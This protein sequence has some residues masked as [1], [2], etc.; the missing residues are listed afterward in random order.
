MIWT[1]SLSASCPREGELLSVNCIFCR[2]SM[3]ALLDEPRIGPPLRELRSCQSCGWW[4]YSLHDGPRLE[5]GPDPEFGWSLAGAIAELKAYDLTD[6]SHPIEEVRQYL[7]AR[8]EA[9]FG[10]H[11][12]LFEDTVTSVFRLLGY[13]AEATAYS[14]DG[15]V[16][17]ILRH[18]DGSSAGVQVKRSKNP[19]EVE[20]IR[21]LAG[22]MILGGHAHGVFVTTSR[23]TSGAK[24]ASEGLAT[25]GLPVELLDANAF[26][27]A[28]RVVRRPPYHSYEDWRECHG[29]P[30]LQTVYD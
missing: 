17:V 20:Q 25:R 27:E 9:R 8:Y 22:A 1:H 5:D 10:C 16:D 28:L 2:G 7:T 30:M 23:F 12:K 3:R 4:A 24:Q 21:A 18:S 29:E 26:L 15:G 6:L 11:P 13:S 14:R 19:I